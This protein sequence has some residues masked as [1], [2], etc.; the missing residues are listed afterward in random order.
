MKKESWTFVFIQ[1]VQQTFTQ[2]LIHSKLS[3]CRQYCQW[4]IL[5]LI[6]SFYLSFLSIYKTLQFDYGS[7][8]LL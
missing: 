7:Y 6:M 4:I 2:I 3:Y 5:F 1:N 8:F